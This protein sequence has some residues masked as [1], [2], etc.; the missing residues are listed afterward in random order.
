M[1]KHDIIVIGAGPAGA[2]AAI[3]A[4]EFGLDVLIVDEALDAGGQ[5]YRIG[6][7]SKASPAETL[8]QRLRDSG[9]QLAFGHRLWTLSKA[10]SGFRAAA[11]G[12][13]S[14]I[15]ADASAVIVATGAIERFYPRPGWTLPGVIGLG[16][17]T[18]MM[19][20]YG[21]LPGQRV[22]V[23]GPGPLAPLVAHLVQQYG[24]KV[25][26]LADPNPRQVWLKALPAIAS[27][28]SLLLEGARWIAS[29]RAKGVP[30]MYG[31]NI[32][33]IEG[34]HHAEYVTL[35]RGTRERRFD[36][37]AVCFGDGLFPSTEIY[38]LLGAEIVY[39]PE[40]G[41]WIPSLDSSQRTTIPKLYAAGDGAELLGVA[42]APLTG[43]IAVLAAARDLGKIT[44]S[45]YHGSWTAERNHLGR[46][47]RFGG[48]FAQMMQPRTWTVAKVPDDTVVCRCEDVTAGQIRNAVAQG[49]TE[50]NALKA[51]TRCGM[52]PC[53][54]RICGDAVAALMECSGIDRKSI[55][56]WTARQPLRPVPI[57]SLTGSFDYAD[58][59]VREP[60]PL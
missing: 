38:R 30:V 22:L 51:A 53:G 10:S 32:R 42:A 5:V 2:E 33:S 28:P 45:E 27:R 15:V 25:V 29:L 52:G 35:V 55:G 23:G 34:A 1:S 6:P 17:A 47:S 7:E 21:V 18:V 56:Y 4:R 48:A 9:T 46:V 31:W 60:A 11:V 54:G 3:A 26:A 57:S 16:A 59:P 8:R 43:R 12:P 50:I 14:T 49:A 20:S 37:D 44:E 39:D 36:V 24:G 13:S 19:K 41:G 40:R 58:I